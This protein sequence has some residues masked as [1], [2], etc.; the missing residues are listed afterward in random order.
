MT[1]HEAPSQVILADVI[2][3]DD[4]LARAVR[5]VRQSTKGTANKKGLR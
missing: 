2:V 5:F 1:E 3:G 4:G